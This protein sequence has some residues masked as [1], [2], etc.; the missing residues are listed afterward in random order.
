MLLSISSVH[1]NSLGRNYSWSFV[2]PNAVTKPSNC[3]N[4]L[5]PNLKQSWRT[6]SP[7]HNGHPTC[8]PDFYL[9][10]GLFLMSSSFSRINRLP[11]KQRT[12]MNWRKRFHP[13]RAL[14]SKTQPPL[15]FR[16][17]VQTARVSYFSSASCQWKEMGGEVFMEEEALWGCQYGQNGVG[18]HFP[19]C[20]Y[21][22]NIKGQI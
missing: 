10:L 8:F 5:S 22:F 6:P 4:H 18:E 3:T 20:F 12:N 9:Y 1:N 11:M 21:D 14:S 7:L 13:H 19:H 15:L 2:S 17:L 16:S